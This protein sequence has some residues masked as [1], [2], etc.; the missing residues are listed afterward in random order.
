MLARRRVRLRW[1]ESDGESQSYL[2]VHLVPREGEKCIVVFTHEKL[3]TGRLRNELRSRW[4]QALENLAD[5]L[6]S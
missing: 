5:S 2:Q 3:K 6:K 4:K 1:S